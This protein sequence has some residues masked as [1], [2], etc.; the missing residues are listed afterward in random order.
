MGNDVDVPH[1]Y[2]FKLSGDASL[3]DISK[4]LMGKR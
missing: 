3:R 2:S 1:S 4:H